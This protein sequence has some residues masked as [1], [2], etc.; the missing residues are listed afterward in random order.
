MTR[1]I[2]IWSGYH[3]PTWLVKPFGH[4]ESFVSISVY[5]YQHALALYQVLTFLFSTREESD[6]YRSE[7]AIFSSNRTR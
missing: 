2:S 6:D 1:T 4:T 7:Y 3:Q 5:E